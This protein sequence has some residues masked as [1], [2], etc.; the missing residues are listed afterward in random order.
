MKFR[1]WQSFLQVRKIDIFRHP[2]L[3]LAIMLSSRAIHIEVSNSLDT[4]SFIHALR[5]F[6]ARRGPIQQIRCDNGTNFIGAKLEL[7]KACGK[8]HHAVIRNRM[9]QAGIEWVF[10]PPAA[11]HMGGVCMG[12]ATEL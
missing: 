6:I 8:M 7:D 4:D 11:G 3:F 1:S 5:R 10:N 2:T 9:H 12:K